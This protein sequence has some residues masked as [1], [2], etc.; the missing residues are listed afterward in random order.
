[1][2]LSYNT[3]PKASSN[4]T[5]FKMAY[6]RLPIV[7]V[8]VF[9][10]IENRATLHLGSNTL[11]HLDNENKHLRHKEKNFMTKTCVLITGYFFKDTA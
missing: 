2:N 7:H 3:V 8:I 6:T 9:K 4:A 10:K 5:F 11:D 1:M